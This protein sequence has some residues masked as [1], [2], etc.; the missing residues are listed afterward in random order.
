MDVDNHDWKVINDAINKWLEEGKVS[1]SQAED[2]RRSF[3][4]K[5]ASQ[6]IAQYFFLIAL[7][8]TLLAFSAIFIDEKIIEKFRKYFDLS[9]WTIAIAMMLIAVSWFAYI[10]RKLSL[11]R[12]AAF[13]I[14]VVLGGLASLTSLVYICKEI[15]FGAN[16]SGFLFTSV[17]L[18]FG[19]SLSFRSKAL[20]IGG[21]AAILGWFGSF[22]YTFSHEHS[23]LGMNYTVRFAL[24][25]AI[26]LALSFYQRK[27]K[28][29]EYSQR[30]SFIAA[31]LVLFVSL[32]GISVFGNFTSFEEWYQVRQT[33]VL[34][35]AFLF[36]AAALLALY[37]GIAYK[38]DMVRDLGILF[39]L[40]NFYSRYFEFL[41]NAMHKGIFFLIL[42]VSFY[43]VGRWIENRRKRSP[44]PGS[45][46][47]PS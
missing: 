3:E 5:K 4:L 12:N 44:I 27:F 24:L 15:G 18:L 16:Y 40:L 46:K 23:F 6:Q 32:W 45:S 9:H 39:L 7:S 8:C 11:V 28:V 17:I 34:P 1:P 36:G 2:M 26:L 22:T 47:A 31:L 37:I 29:L 21:I 42:A 33:R 13:E 14:Y 38:D 20:W 25:G 19:L 41:W 35:Y 10:R 30:I 43:F